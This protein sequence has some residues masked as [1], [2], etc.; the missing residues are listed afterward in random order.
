MKNLTNI[1]IA[2]VILGSAA[3]G[4]SS[5]RQVPETVQ[6]CRIGMNLVATPESRAHFE[7]RDGCASF[8]WDAGNSMVAVV[9]K[10]GAIAGW[11][12]GAFCS[13]M[14]ITLIDP[15]ALNKVSRATS[16]LTLAPDATA[17][18]EGFYCL[19]PVNGSSECS[20]EQTASEV[21]AL[22]RLPSTFDQSASGKLE[23]FEPW[24]FIHGESEVLRGPSSDK[25]FAAKTTYFYA[26]PATFRFNV[27]NNTPED[28]RME[29]VK[30]TCNKLFPDRLRWSTDGSAPFIGETADKSGYFNT[31]KTSINSGFGEVLN[32]KDGETVTT[33]TYYSMCLPYDDAAAL[34]GAT[35]ALI[36]ESSEK[37]Y[38]F[39]ISADEFFPDPAARKFESNRIYT[40]N[41]TLNANSV[42]LE[43][44]TISDWV[45]D[46][47]FLPTEDVTA[48]VILDASYWI[49]ERHNIYTYGFAKMFSD[50]ATMW[51]EC[52]I[53]EYLYCATDETFFWSEVTPSDPSDED[54][55]A[56]YFDFITDFKWKTPSKTDYDQLFSLPDEN[57]TILKD[58]ESGVFGLQFSSADNPGAKFFLPC[59]GLTDEHTDFVGK[60]TITTRT[61]H[62]YYWTRDEVDES[63]AWIL[64][65]S[66]RQVETQEEET[67]SFSDFTKVLSEGSSLYEFQSVR[68]D[69][70][71][72]VRPV[73]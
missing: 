42:E 55:L 64:H 40:F 36:L 10:G 38:T 16:S 11:N 32:A 31:I 30:I 70:L 67:T 72:T 37:T 19:S 12:G 53:G 23:E 69:N 50:P 43:S 5:E 61:Y 22:M 46:P 60:S 9:T 24:C 62:G 21:S 7:D 25:N 52:N 35:L 54:Y 17:A 51:G 45:G 20:L 71:Y 39:N 13:P 44:V 48:R 27:K 33:G 59:S 58:S 29:S 73:L 63:N 57:I 41:V 66:F 4:C 14:N 8:V 2:T 65:F 3:V 6:G 26:I 15:L 49:Q 47:F 56:P 28:V 68:K 34:S 1:L 18:G